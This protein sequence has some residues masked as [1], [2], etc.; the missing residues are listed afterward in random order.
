MVVSA[1]QEQGPE[2]KSQYWKKIN[3]HFSQI[4]S[5]YGLYLLTF[6]EKRVREKENQV[7]S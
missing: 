5:V 6:W 4:L 3:S 1:K 7:K 2:Y